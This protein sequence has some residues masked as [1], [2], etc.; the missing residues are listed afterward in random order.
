VDETGTAH[1]GQPARGEL[2]NERENFQAVTGILPKLVDGGFELFLPWAFTANEGMVVHRRDG[3]HELK[4]L[5]LWIQAQLN[6]PA[7]EAP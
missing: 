3:S 5:P 1:A 4:A 6:A 2:W 7:G